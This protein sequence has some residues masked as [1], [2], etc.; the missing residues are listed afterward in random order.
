MGE[1]ELLHAIQQELP[2][3]EPSP[4]RP[5]GLAIAGDEATLTYVEAV[6]GEQLDEA[7]E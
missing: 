6:F 1:H 5:L 7:D 4:L 2:G 3:V